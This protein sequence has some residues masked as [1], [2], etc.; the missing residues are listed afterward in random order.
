MK[1]KEVRVVNIAGNMITRECWRK[2]LRSKRR[3]QRSK[4]MSKERIEVETVE[5][6]N[7]PEVLKR[8]KATQI[9]KET[10]EERV[11]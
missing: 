4:C 7:R 2:V 1:K 10:H 9:M 5:K 6:V 11:E 3:L 8:N